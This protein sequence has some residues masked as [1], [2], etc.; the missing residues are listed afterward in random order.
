MRFG[1]MEAARE[2]R[3][4]KLIANESNIFFDCDDTLVLWDKPDN[5]PVDSVDRLDIMCPYEGR[6]L[7]VYRH[8]P[9]IKL[10]INHAARGSHIT[11]WS[12]SGYQWAEA[13]VKA[14]GL[15]PYVHVIMSKP[16]AH[17][18]DLPASEWMGERIYLQPDSPWGNK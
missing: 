18:D 9:H 12:A 1:P 2:A 4:Y 8:N 11:V 5:I 15:E 13:V 6:P 3:N 17:V 7:C 16:R 14:L 10:L